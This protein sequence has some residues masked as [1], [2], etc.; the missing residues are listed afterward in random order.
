MCFLGARVRNRNQG[1]T[2]A[3]SRGRFR[4]LASF[5]AQA[6]REKAYLLRCDMGAWRAESPEGAI[7]GS[8]EPDHEEEGGK[9]RRLE[10]VCSLWL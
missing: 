8:H 4:W 3:H 10:M 5:V 9:R 1:T 7:R 2:A 6:R